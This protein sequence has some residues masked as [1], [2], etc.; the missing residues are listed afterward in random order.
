MNLTLINY[1]MNTQSPVFSHQRDVAIALSPHFDCVTVFTTESSAEKLPPNMSVVVIP[2]VRN[3][4]IRNAFKIFK[5]IVPHLIHNRSSIVFTHMSDIHAALISPITRFAK[6]RH[7]LWYAHAS[8]SLFLKISALFVSN[9]VSSTPG[10][11]NLKYFRNKIIYIN[12]GIDAK[13]FPSLPYRSDKLQK[14]V[15]YGRLD[16]SKN[17]KPLF[18]IM[19][20]LR[21][22][23]SNTSLNVYGKSMNKESESY[24]DQIKEQFHSD[25][26]KGHF[27]I[28]SALSRDKISQEMKKYG[29]FINLFNGSLDK[30]LVEATFMGLAV[31]T[32][33]R[34][35]C[36]QFGTW[37][38]S[39]V[40][41]TKEFI[42]N[43]IV[44][45]QNLSDLE[46]T[47]ALNRRLSYA[48]ENHTFEG[49]L[50]RLLNIISP[51]EESS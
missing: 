28:K 36:N 7:V 39:P 41:E 19:S 18:E 35:F 43:E 9:I 8:N 4:N 11:C 47:K 20:N 16:Q 48:L 17:I 27:S 50:K 45:I 34:E 49:W 32:W 29:V 37:S 31:V 26:N 38:N 15:Y 44:I 40:E 21:K 14:F 6:M 25:L 22:S 24:M 1:S 2:W 3:S 5:A 46:L 51:Q 10:S 42:L 12:Q 30:T 23:D 33:N 13:L